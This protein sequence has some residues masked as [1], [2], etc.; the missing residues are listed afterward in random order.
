MSQEFNPNLFPPNGYVFKDRDGTRHQ[1]DSW[2][3][4]LQQVVDYRTR[5]GFELGDVWSEIMAQACASTPG[6]CRDNAPRLVQARSQTGIPA[7][8]QRVLEWLN[9]A[10][11]LKRVNALVRV[12]DGEAARRAKICLQCP[13]QHPLNEVCHACLI[14]TKMARKLILRGGASRHQN[15]NPCGVLGEDCQT[16]VYLEQPPVEPPAPELPAEC[17]RKRSL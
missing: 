1:S 6:H 12:S 15:L 13:R 3:R 16:S 11:T 14:T 9:Q 5:N 7:F 8:N 4:L 2:K 10:L 17:W